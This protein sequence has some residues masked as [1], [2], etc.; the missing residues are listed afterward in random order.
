MFHVI[1]LAKLN[2]CRELQVLCTETREKALS[3]VALAKTVRKDLENEDSNRTS[4]CC[5][6]IADS[7]AQLKVVVLHLFF[8]NNT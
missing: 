7:L 8:H 3:V 5:N 2:I 6:I 4:L 1:R